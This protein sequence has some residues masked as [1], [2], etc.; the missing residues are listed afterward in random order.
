MKSAK[1]ILKYQQRIVR[2]LKLKDYSPIALENAVMKLNEQ[3]CFESYTHALQ[4]L[5][6][7]GRISYNNGVV[8][9]TD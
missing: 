7:N 3:C 8:K 6:A 9:I 2:L 4:D 5:I 1:L